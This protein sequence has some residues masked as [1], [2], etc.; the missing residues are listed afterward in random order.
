MGMATLWLIAMRMRSVGTQGWCGLSNRP[1]KS[2]KAHE[3]SKDKGVAKPIQANE[4]LPFLQSRFAYKNHHR[5]HK[6]RCDEQI[7]CP[8][9][10]VAN[11]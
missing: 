9:Y 1:N 3:E 8:E 11:C 6:G 2:Y 10:R 7:D 4:F 5:S